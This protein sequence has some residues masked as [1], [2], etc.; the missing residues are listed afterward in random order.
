MMKRMT[1]ISKILTITAVMFLH[2]CASKGEIDFKSSEADTRNVVQ[3]T[4]ECEYL[5]IQTQKK[6]WKNPFL[7]PADIWNECMENRGYS[8]LGK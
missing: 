8:L 3:D 2:G 4:M 6:N 5:A 1:L 7:E